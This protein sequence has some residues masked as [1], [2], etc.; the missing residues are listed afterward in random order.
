MPLPLS[1]L[2]FI[3]D[4]RVRGHA[5]SEFITLSS[6]ELPSVSIIISSESATC[7]APFYSATQTKKECENISENQK[8]IDEAENDMVLFLHTKLRS[9]FYCRS[10]RYCTRNNTAKSVSLTDCLNLFGLKGNMDSGSLW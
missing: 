8:R 2:Y 3:F 10:E 4:E 1:F 7:Q 5:A 9:L 6:S